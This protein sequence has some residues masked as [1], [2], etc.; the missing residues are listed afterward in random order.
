MKCDHSFSTMPIAMVIFAHSCVYHNIFTL[1]AGLSWCLCYLSNDSMFFVF[2]CEIYFLC[3]FIVDVVQ[4][5]QTL[6][7]WNHINE[8]FAS[9]N[10]PTKNEKQ[11][12]IKLWFILVWCPQDYSKTFVGNQHR[13]NTTIIN[14]KNIVCFVLKYTIFTLKNQENLHQAP[15]NNCKL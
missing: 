9:N 11:S 12:T 3:C 6:K 5:I 8:T 2:L 15:N 4:V 14:P 10:V 13:T 1:S 7:K